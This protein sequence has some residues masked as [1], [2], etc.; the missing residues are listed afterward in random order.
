LGEASKGTATAGRSPAGPEELGGASRRPDV[1]DPGLAAPQR[2]RPEPSLGSSAEAARASGLPSEVVD[3]GYAYSRHDLPDVVPE[4]GFARA[5]PARQTPPLAQER[6]R[7][8]AGRQPTTA[9]D[10][11]DVQNSTLAADLSLIEDHIAG[12]NRGL[13]SGSG[14]TLEDVRINRTQ[15]AEGGTGPMRASSHTRPDM[16]FTIRDPQGRAQRFLIE[17]DRSPPTRALGHARGILERDPT[18]I[19]ILKVIGFE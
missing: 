1:D 17:Y 7:G 19:V 10:P 3:S 16:Q 18:A 2:L 5:R 9:P 11:A 14:W 4:S 6:A 12:L 13:P 8:V 15:V